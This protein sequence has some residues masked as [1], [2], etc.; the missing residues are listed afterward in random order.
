MTDARTLAYADHPRRL[1]DLHLPRTRGPW[2]LM[3]WS[4]GSAWS[5]D[6]GR[7]GADVVAARLGPHGFAVAGVAI[8]ASSQAVFPAQLDDVVAAV[9]HLQEHAARYGLD[10]GRF[11]AMGESSGGWAAA[12]AALTTGGLVKAAICFYPPTD[13]LR[14]DE[15]MPPGAMQEFARL[16]GAPYGHDHPASPESRLLGGPLP[17]M[18]EAA[19]QA[20]PLTYVDADAPPFLI[21]HGRQD[22]L[23]PYGQSEL[24]YEAL[25][26]AGT[27]AELVCLPHAGHGQWRRFL[28]DPATRRDACAFSTRDDPARPRPVD[29]TWDDIAAFLRRALATHPPAPAP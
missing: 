5:A 9:E 11:A 28:T 13:L 3:I 26:K 1:L 24:L 10:P 19:A 14:M 15:Q 17:V 29:P 6:N 16:P 12:M 4:H 2:P 18:A 23:V 27:E 8:R 20:S 25:A 21:L 22:P 7:L